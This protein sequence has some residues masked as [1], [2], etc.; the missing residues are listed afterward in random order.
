LA[1][2][3][4]IGLAG[5][6][7]INYFNF[8]DDIK[9]VFFSELNRLGSAKP[10]ELGLRKISSLSAL[11]ISAGKM[12]P[13]F[14]GGT[15]KYTVTLPYGT[16]DVPTVA[17]A[18]PTDASAKA[19]IDDAT[20]LTD[21]A[22]ITVTAEDP[23][24]QS[25]YV[26]YFAITPISKE[27]NLSSLEISSGTLSPVFSAD[28]TEYTD[29]LPAGTTT[30][31]TVTA[32]KAK[33]TFATVVI[34]DATSFDADAII[35]VTAQDVT[36]TKVYKINYVL[37]VGINNS[38][39]SNVTFYPNPASDRLTFRNATS[40]RNI[41]IMNMSGQIIMRVNQWGSSI[42]ISGL[43]KGVYIVR[44]TNNDNTTCIS[45]LIKK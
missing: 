36:V 23:T 14:T 17:T 25:V 32:A 21:S 31:P 15:L 33:S 26:V 10:A 35:T 41:E 28:V 13:G 29:T 27:A 6:G 8:P 30:I 42:N 37:A 4:Y 39:L 3:T 40:I 34:V 11:A 38:S 22:T 20:S 44:I 12:A 9:E 16:T 43:S 45:K 7:G 24:V 2:R 1:E 19:V 5:D 18:T